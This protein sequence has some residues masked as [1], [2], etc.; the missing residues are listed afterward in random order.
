MEPAARKHPQAV[1]SFE[2]SLSASPVAVA[3]MLGSESFVLIYQV[4]GMVGGLLLGMILAIALSSLQRATGA[5]QL[6]WLTGE[7]VTGIGAICGWSWGLTR[8][9]RAH[10]KRFLAA[11]RSRG[12]PTK[13]AATFALGE[14]ELSVDTPRVKYQIPFGV[15]LEVVETSKAW[16]IQVD[17]TTFYLPK[18]AFHN[19]ER[20][21]ASASG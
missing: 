2:E 14:A 19:K 13:M 8:A 6:S 5:E 7:L 1:V 15:I 4:A 17:L 12:A 11:I 3:R 9:Q 10:R 20:E 16:L 18:S 21:R